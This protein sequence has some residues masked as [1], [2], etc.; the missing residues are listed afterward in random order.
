LILS[1]VMAAAI[2]CAATMASAAGTA[3]GVTAP[4]H[5]AGWVK[6]AVKSGVAAD[7]ASVTIAVHMTL[8]NAAALKTLAT[9]VSSPASTQYGHY[10]TTQEFGTRFSPAAAD[11]NAIKALLEQ[12]GMKDVEVGPYGVYVSATATVAQL[13]ATFKVSQNLY[14]YKGWTLRANSE[15]PTIPAVLA[16]KVLYIQGLD[17]T[18]LMRT[19]FHRSVAEGA[20][21]APAAASSAN[22]PA[23][24]PPP[25]AANN[26]SPFCN[27]YYGT[28][29][30]VGTLSTPADVYGAAI[31]WLNCGYT[32]QQIQAAYGLNAVKFT[33]KGVT[34][35]I[36][37]A[38]AS[39][40]LQSDSNRYAARHG[41]P[42]L[43]T[44][45]NFS[46]II[47]LGIYN[48]NPAETCGPYGW[49]E[50]QSLDMASV[51]GTAPDA[52]IVYVGARDCGT[53]LDVAFANTVYNHVA[54]I[55][56]NSWG[57]N[58]EAIAPGSQA[59]YDQALQAGAVQGMTVLFSS[60]DNGDLAAA[61][62][63]ASGS[64]P[65]T[66]AWATGVGGTTLEIMDSTGAKAEYGWGTYRAF[67]NDVTVNSAKS[68]TTSGLATVT[69]FGYTYDDFSFYA[70]SGGG[71]SLLEKQPAYQA[72]DVPKYLATTLNLASGYTEP[73]STRQRVS[74]DVAMDADPYTGYLF[75]ETFTIAGNPINDHGCNP[76]S[77]TEEYCEA[78]I[79]GTSVAS[80]LFAGVMAV[81]NQKRMAAGQPLVGF[82]NP[83]FYSVGSRGDGVNLTTAP[84]NQITA[85]SEPV[86]LLRG[87]AAN[88]NELRVVTINS[89]PFNITT[90]PYA[91]FVCG[92]PVCLGINEMWNYTSL[93]SVSVP[94]TPAGYNDVTGLGVPYVPRL[95]YQE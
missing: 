72:P 21:V 39:P 14:S 62:G 84:L 11:V 36:T 7:N 81:M 44:G 52:N 8:Q 47:P 24:T 10:L 48:V 67:L 45:V 42:K 41:L 19:P 92:V 57:S 46:Q 9:A 88:L 32:P 29:A 83:L 40:T 64:W 79:G 38:Y 71:I 90:A 16:G 95:I 60:G 20:L 75:G 18:A 77:A 78:A 1:G 15:D 6:N 73:L 23:V 13:R 70:G 68:V 3:A 22:K 4:G 30:L 53:S 61:N 55:V 2:A 59:F 34:V 91:L 86:S 93:S 85:P 5:V 82:A 50:E 94:P 58:G 43:V 12:A 66:S 25:V 35:A 28:G 65:A 87:Y 80:P 54:D 63:V 26:P 17:D 37:D 69:N 33:G 27:K 89:V 74:P 51:H 31:P 76:I 56:T 49:W